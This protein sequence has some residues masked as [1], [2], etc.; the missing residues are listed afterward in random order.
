MKRS[1]FIV[2]LVLVTFTGCNIG[3]NCGRSS[4]NIFSRMCNSLRG[5]SDVGAPCASGMC[6][7]PPMMSGPMVADGCE[8]CGPS[9]TMGYESYEGQGAPAFG[10]S[11]NMFNGGAENVMPVPASR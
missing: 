6:N 1:S 3:Q 2:V 4:S 10:T 11:T 9:T 8:T 7:A 5:V